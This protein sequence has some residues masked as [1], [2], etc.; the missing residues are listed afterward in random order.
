MG[1]NYWNFFFKLL[2]AVSI[3]SVGKGCLGVGCV[4][5]CIEWLLGMHWAGNGRGFRVHKVNR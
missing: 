1:P 4:D 3:Q 5:L 2:E